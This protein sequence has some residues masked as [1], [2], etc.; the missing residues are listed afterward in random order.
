MERISIGTF[1]ASLRKEKGMTQ[2]QLAQLLHVSDKA[3]SRWERD[4]AQPDL[5]Q[6]SIM[7]EIFGVTADELLKGRRSQ[8]GSYQPSQTADRS[9]KNIRYSYRIKTSISISLALAGTLASLVC[10]YGF[11]NSSA[12]LLGFLIGL[13]FYLTT[14]IFQTLTALGAQ[15]DI[16]SVQCESSSEPGP[17][18]SIISTLVNMYIV[19]L[20]LLVG[21]TPVL[22]RSIGLTDILFWGPAL[23]LPLAGILLR[24]KWFLIE[25]F[26]AS[27]G[28]LFQSNVKN[29][30]LRKLRKE[31][32]Y[33]DLILCGVLLFYIW[34][35]T[36]AGG[37]DVV[38]FAAVV[39]LVLELPISTLIY[40]IRK[41]NKIIRASA[42]T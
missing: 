24:L 18:D 25:P 9:I 19:L 17:L 36:L 3:I 41:S 40:R 21:I 20:A 23:S 10:T 16:A 39:I 29:G 42:Q 11:R 8:N 31:T 27:R 26:I 32:I 13:G 30:Q 35:Y 4:E 7:T 5:L 15:Q 1:I 28:N 33:W 22:N 14:G 37:T 6:I 12:H 2:K 38:F 34:G